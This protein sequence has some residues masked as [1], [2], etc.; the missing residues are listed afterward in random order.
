MDSVEYQ[1]QIDGRNCLKL[2]ANLPAM[3]TPVEAA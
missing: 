3:P 2:A 1:S